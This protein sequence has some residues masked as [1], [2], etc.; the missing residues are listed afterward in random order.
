MKAAVLKDARELVI[1]EVSE[2]QME[3][4]EILVKVAACGICGSDLH[5]Y[6]HGSLSPDLRLGHE[7][8]GTVTEVGKGA[9]G[10]NVG[11]RVAVLGRVPCGECH[12][13]K[14]GRHH[15]CPN[16]LDVRGGFSEF[17]AVK[18]QMLAL[19]PDNMTFRQGA[20]MEPM[21]VCLHGIKLAGIAANDGVVVTGAGPIGL[22]TAALLR[23][24]GV[25]GL[26]VSEPS[27]PRREIASIWADRVVDPA[28]EDMADAAHETLD[29]GIDALVECSGQAAVLEE[30]FNTIGFAGRILLLGA[31]L[32]NINFNPASLLVREIAFQGSYGCDMEEFRR[33][34]ELVSGGSIDVNPVI[35][36]TVPQDELPHA[37][38]RLCEPNDE[39]KLLMEIG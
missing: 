37:L 9:E 12:W 10:F 8:V 13:C 39:V 30:V 28:K 4:D 5:L 34:I 11:D 32:E 14:R 36:G 33:C 19:L 38:E 29:P 31:C 20:V 16:R 7:S 24:M 17:V 15:V 1:E 2:P 21:A 35:S 26:V 23:H 3:D 25:R 18:S 22:F 27:G 6:K